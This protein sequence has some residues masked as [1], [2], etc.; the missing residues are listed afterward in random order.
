MPE[1]GDVI[2]A[3]IGYADSTQSKIR[4][5]VVL[6][7]EPDNFI[8]ATVTSNLKRA[9]IPISKSE[10]AVVD[11]VIRPNYIF[12]IAKNRISKVV[13]KLSKEKRQLLFKEIAKRFEQLTEV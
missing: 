7:V 9:G 5:A 11:S 4:P 1:S 13:F 8:I 10:G 12:T 6:F 2:V 3:Q